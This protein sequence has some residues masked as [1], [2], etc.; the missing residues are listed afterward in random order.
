MRVLHV[1]TNLGTGGAESMLLRLVSAGS[2]QFQH[3]VISLKEEGTNGPRMRELGIP[4]YALGL[5]S[6]ASNPLRAWSVRSLAR[7]VQPDLIHGW[8]NHGNL[9]AYLAAGATG[10]RPPVIWNIRQT[11]KG[12][13]G[14]LPTVAIIRVNAHLSRRVAKIIYNSQAGRREHEALG[15][16][17]SAGVVIPNGIDCQS[18]APDEK[19]RREVRSELGLPNDAILIGL[20]ARYDPIKDHRGFL[21]AAALV[22]RSV[23]EARFLLVG[24][25]VPEA[26]ELQEFIR[27]LHLQDR[28]L[29]LGDRADMPRLNGSLDIGCSSSRTEGFSNT[30]SEAMACGVPCVVTDVGD[31]SYVVD[32][33][34]IAVQPGDPA[35]FAEGLKKLLLAGPDYRRRLGAAARRRIESQFSLPE[36]VRR[37]ED[38]YER[39]RESGEYAIDHGTPA[40]TVL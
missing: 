13:P 26:V 38:L 36:I 34:G 12:Y 5:E 6:M 19:C 40:D 23:A 1:I 11:L 3:A 4:V 7:R 32:D 17:T 39:H 27:E 10:R 37:Y 18:F 22:S 21:Q 24:P 31:S 9:L 8:M 29:L 30:V 16:R 20:V 14:K 33:T 35:A 28:V 2:S 15:Y 25:G